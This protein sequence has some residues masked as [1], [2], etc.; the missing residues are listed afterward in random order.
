MKTGIDQRPG[1]RADARIAQQAF[2]D[3]RAATLDRKLE[4]RLLAVV[5]WVHALV[6]QQA[7]DNGQFSTATRPRERVLVVGHVRVDART[8][9]KMHRRHVAVIGRLRK[10][11][12]VVIVCA[13]LVLTPVGPKRTFLYFGQRLGRHVRV[14]ARARARARDAF[15]QRA[16]EMRDTHKHGHGGIA[17]HRGEHM[18]WQVAEACCLV[19]PVHLA[20]RLVHGR[21]MKRAQDGSFLATSMD[22][23]R[24]G[25]V[26]THRWALCVWYI[27][28]TGATSSHRFEMVTQHLAR[29]C[30]LRLAWP[31]ADIGDR[32]QYSILVTTNAWIEQQALD[33]P[34][35]S[36][37]T[38]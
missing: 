14:R 5:A 24:N 13:R 23:G 10:V 38:R 34:H 7:L 26:T 30:A 18:G 1:S 36:I 37:A 31:V 22:Q 2:Y 16:I 20:A 35:L 21:A 15:M 4:R 25:C 32:T 19:V 28:N 8:Q 6:A 27:H 29:S 3:G 11:E 33:A 9:E 12:F 17:Q